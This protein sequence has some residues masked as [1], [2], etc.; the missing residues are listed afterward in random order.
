MLP[1]AT[2]PARWRV[3]TAL[4][5]P[6]FVER[7]LTQTL[8]SIL[9]PGNLPALC[10]GETVEYRIL[11][12]AADAIALRTHPLFRRL[13]SLLRVEFVLIDDVAGAA[14][15]DRVS[16]LHRLAMKGAAQS[17]IGLIFFVPDAI[18]SDGT[19]AEVKSIAKAG[20]QAIAMD[21]PRVVR[22]PFMSDLAAFRNGDGI[23]SVRSRELMELAIRHIHPNEAAWSWNSDLLHD[24]P[25]QLHWPVKGGGTLTR[26]FCSLPLYVRPTRDISEFSGA[27]DFGLLDAVVD[28]LR[29]IYYCRDS[30]EMTVATIDELGF[31]SANFKRVDKH[32]RVLQVAKWLHREHNRQVLD[33]IR[34]PCRR[35]FVDIDEQ[36]WLRAER[37]SGKHVD[38]VLACR[39]ILALHDALLANGLNGAAGLLA[40]GLY[41]RGL[42]RRLGKPGVST[43]F[44]PTDEALE[45]SGVWTGDGLMIPGHAA[46]FHA[47]LRRCVLPG[48]LSAAEIAG[49]RSD[50]E[51]VLPDIEIGANILHGIDRVPI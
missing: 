9:S 34:H 17:D 42:S 19:L 29:A 7:F 36:A 48:R 40:F 31:S 4:W 20:Y 35:H 24:V 11:T 44:A 47:A 5:G 30:D 45:R 3:M 37:L 15:Y 16:Q 33:A 23:I 21:G 32:E 13:Q 51:I 26:C 28:D 10:H 22:R 8:P 12:E 49:T 38:A 46:E 14:K 1:F 2:G 18:W 27:I 25:F 6:R 39:E 41:Q 50:F 43:F